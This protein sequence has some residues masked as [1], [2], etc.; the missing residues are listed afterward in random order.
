MSHIHRR[1][2]VRVE[3]FDGF[4]SPGL[5]FFTFFF[6]PHDGLPVGGQDQAGA[7]VGDFHAVA[8][9]LV[10]VEEKC[11]LHG[12]LVR[13]G[14]DEDAVFQENVGGAQNILAGID[15]VGDVVE[16]AAR[17]GMVA[18]V[19]EIVALVAHRHPHRGFGAVVQHDLL[20]Q[21]AAEIFLEENAVGL[22]VDREAIEMIE[23][24]HID[25]ARRKALAWFFRAGRS[26]GGA[27]YHSVS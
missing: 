23:A 19:G 14:F 22:D 24:A 16:A 18:G 11:L 10:D 3:R 9:G 15:G 12:V 5:S 13:A 7:G 25:A 2:S 8:A 17:A 6:R 20:G 26:S 1:R 21:P 27:L 4:E